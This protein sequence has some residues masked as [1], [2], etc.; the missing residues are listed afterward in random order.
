MHHT[1]AVLVQAYCAS[2]IN[3]A[4]QGELN[5]VKERRV[6]RER[7]MEFVKSSID[8]IGENVNSKMSSM[9]SKLHRL[10]SALQRTR[11]QQE[12][13]LTQFEIEKANLQSMIKCLHIREAESEARESQQNEKVMSLSGK[14]SALQ[15][16]SV[17]RGKYLTLVVPHLSWNTRRAT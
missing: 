15:E 14:L 11:S 17:R 12:Q 10:E 5:K 6:I 8:V 7:L 16:S 9:I 1:A 4:V 3:T 13:S 2:G